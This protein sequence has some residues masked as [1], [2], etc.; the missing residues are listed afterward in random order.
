MAAR[1]SH[2]IVNVS[3]GRAE[4]LLG[5]IQG[6]GGED[7]ETALAKEKTRFRLAGQEQVFEFLDR[8]DDTEKNELLAQCRGIDLDRVGKLFEATMAADAKGGA[9]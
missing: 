4:Q 6:K 9:M 7:L 8:L 5:A 1:E 2:S 3:K